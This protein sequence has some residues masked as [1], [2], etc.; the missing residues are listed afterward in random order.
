[1]EGSQH[2]DGRSSG[3]D[4]EPGAAANPEICD[5]TPEEIDGVRERKQS[6]DTSGA[7]GVDA[8]FAQEERERTADE[9]EG[10]D[11]IGRNEEGEEPGTIVVG[12]GDFAAN[13]RRFC[14][15]HE[16]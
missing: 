7:S 8:L 10:D 9:S 6:H 5:R 11:G 2:G 13:L 3:G 1:M 15:L 4:D 14:R 12:S 16:A